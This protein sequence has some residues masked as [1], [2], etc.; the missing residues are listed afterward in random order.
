M[1]F[2]TIYLDIRYPY[3]SHAVISR[4]SSKSDF[5]LGV[6]LEYLNLKKVK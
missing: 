4:I 6:V 5:R 2:N 3:P 1:Q